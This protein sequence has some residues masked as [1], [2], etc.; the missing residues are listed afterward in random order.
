MDLRR[1]RVPGDQAD[2]SIIFRGARGDRLPK[3]EEK[4]LYDR[5]PGIRVAY[6][7][8]ARAD[9]RFCNWATMFF[10]VAADL[11]AAG[12]ES[13]VAIGMDN[14]S[15]QRTPGMLQLYKDLGLFAFYTP[16]DCT[17]CVSPVDH[18]IGSHIQAFMG[19]K[20]RAEL[21]TNPNIW[22][23]SGEDQEIDDANSKSAMHR[24]MLMVTWLWEA[25][26]DLCK[27]HKHKLQQSF[28]NTGFLLA[29]DGSEDSETRLQGWSS[30]S[31]YTFRSL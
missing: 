19:K 29:M 28:F 17:D 24:R 1:A 14:H 23:A 7:K 13:E 8:N 25:W 16:A 22:I 20:Y 26:E 15:C 30:T 11:A 4:A 3:K 27:N 6:Q 9:E 2:Y 31:P 21:E 18:H 10:N 12:V 5:F